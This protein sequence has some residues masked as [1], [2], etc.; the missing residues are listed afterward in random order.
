MD[1]Y[2]RLEQDHDKQRTLIDRIKQ[3]EPGSETRAQ[4]WT[5][6]KIEL[7][8]H[9]SAEE[10]AFYSKLMAEPEGTDDTR[11]AIEEHQQMHE[12]TAKLDAMDQS[13]D[14]WDTLFGKLAHKVVHHVDEEEEEFFPDAKETLSDSQEEEALRMF[15][16]RKAAEVDKQEELAD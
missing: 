12:M 16:K 11:H 15:N 13:A 5:D 4:L 14:V 8:A 1:I 2:E 9:A 3:S 7:E 6:L 10:Q